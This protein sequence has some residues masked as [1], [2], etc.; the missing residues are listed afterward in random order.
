M[1]S[2]LK[3]YHKLLLTCTKKQKSV[4]MLEHSL[5]LSPNHN[6]RTPVHPPLGAGG[7]RSLGWRRR[8]HPNCS[9]SHR[10]A[11]LCQKGKAGVG[12]VSLMLAIKES[13]T[14]CV[15]VYLQDDQIASF[16]QYL[17][18]KN[19]G[20]D[21]QV[22]SLYFSCPTVTENILDHPLEG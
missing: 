21:K 12:R 1:S 10:K 5:F 13:L 19:L 9:M 4:P 11:K 7:R 2:Y 6:T 17:A 8:E 20:M 3:I 14:P 16:I 15:Y 22:T 18:H